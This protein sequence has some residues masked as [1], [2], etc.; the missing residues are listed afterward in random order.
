MQ[1][2]RRSG[3]PAAEHTA[4]IPAS[5]AERGAL[6]DMLFS[7]QRKKDARFLC[8]LYLRNSFVTYSTNTN[9]AD[10]GDAEAQPHLF[11]RI[12]AVRKSA[13]D[14]RAA[15]QHQEGGDQGYCKCSAELELPVI[16]FVFFFLIFPKEY[17]MSFYSPPF[18][19][20]NT[21]SSS[22]RN[23]LLPPFRTSSVNIFPSF[24]TMTLSQ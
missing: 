6:Q 4:V 24:I 1:A 23:S 13:L 3:R 2:P 16:S 11:C 21:V 8:F 15:H 14:Q 9:T 18:K 20:F 10:G 17:A 19:S 5:S 22:S 7:A 12:P